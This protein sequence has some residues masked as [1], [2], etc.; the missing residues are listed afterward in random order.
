MRRA[1][2]ATAAVLILL[3]G[4]SAPGCV[5]Y[6]IVN[7]THPTA[8]GTVV[9]PRLAPKGR[10]MVIPPSGT[11]RGQFDNVIALFEREFLKR[12][13][14]VISG[15]VTGRVVIDAG[16]GAEKRVEAA[17][18]LSDAERALIMA[19]ETGADAILQIGQFVWSDAPVATRF[20][21]C[22]GRE[23]KGYAEVSQ[24]EYQA[25]SGKKAVMTSRWLAFVGRLMDVQNGEVLASFNMGAGANFNLQA[26]Q[27]VPF[28]VQRR[29]GPR[30]AAVEELWPPESFPA[31]NWNTATAVTMEKVIQTVAERISARRAGGH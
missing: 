10:V 9:S 23:S 28:G 18:G 8:D 1:S 27:Q 6:T 19:K 20:F 12:G 3:V 2:L 14:T 17:A 15:A 31:V 24:E 7:A 22:C 13:I 30:G 21:T 26:N 11:V 4:L 16:T 5:A 29:R 25:W